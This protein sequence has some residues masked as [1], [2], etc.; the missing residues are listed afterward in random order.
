M[1]RTTWYSILTLKLQYSTKQNTNT[2]L[3]FQQQNTANV[4]LLGQL[5][6]IQNTRKE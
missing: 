2:M 4:I 5:D 3:L 1:K 6:E